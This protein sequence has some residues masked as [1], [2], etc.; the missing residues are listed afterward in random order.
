MSQTLTL[1]P[2]LSPD[3]E[4]ARKLSRIMAVIFAIAFWG[5]LLGLLA[6]P[7]VM[8]VPHDNGT[9]GL[10][11]ENISIGGLSVLQRLQVA[12][13]LAVGALPILFLMRHTSRVFGYFAKGEIFVAP[14][15]D[16]IRRAGYWLI[17]YFFAG[18]ASH[19]TLLLDGL[20]P[21]GHADLPFWPLIIGIITT[22]L[23]YVMEEARRIAADHAE[24]V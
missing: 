23:A 5:M 6:M 16:H 17:A 19:I 18:I 20:I 11:G 10:G 22:I 15:I 1:T 7:I 12:F 13:A 4:R 21:K 24:I 8:A 3:F 9:I 2:A 14:V